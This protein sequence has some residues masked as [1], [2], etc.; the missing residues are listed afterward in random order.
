MM[1]TLIANLVAFPLPVSRPTLARTYLVTGLSGQR[2]LVCSDANANFCPVF[3]RKCLASLS[4]ANLRTVFRSLGASRQGFTIGPNAACLSEPSQD[5]ITRA[6][7]LKRDVFGGKLLMYVEPL[8][9]LNVKR[10][11]PATSHVRSLANWEDDQ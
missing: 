1:N 10:N 9:F 4:R 3:F 11:K 2:T 8:D 7:K 6:A 5:G